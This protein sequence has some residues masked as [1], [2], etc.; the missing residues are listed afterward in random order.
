MF[1]KTF[2]TIFYVVYNRISIKMFRHY[3]YLWNSFDEHFILNKSK[4][5]LWMF[6][7]TIIVSKVVLMNIWLSINQNKLIKMKKEHFI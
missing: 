3:Y 6:S 7:N 1:Q 2:Y 4:Y 5:S